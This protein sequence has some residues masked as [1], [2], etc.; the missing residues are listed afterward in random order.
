MD[1]GQLRRHVPPLL[2]LVAVGLLYG[3]AGSLLDSGAFETSILYFR[4]V[5]ALRSEISMQSGSAELPQVR[6]ER[7]SSILEWRFRPERLTAAT[8]DFALD[9]WRT[10]APATRPL[11]LQADSADLAWLA[12]LKDSTLLNLVNLAVRENRDV[13]T[14]VA[15]IREFR[16]QVGVTRSELFPELSANGSAST[17]QIA[18]TIRR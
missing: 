16:A 18:L 11:A 7:A 17:N 4:E 5:D 12:V 2:F 14:A 1:A 15:R 6:L 9:C 8:A 13:Q 10:A 3:V